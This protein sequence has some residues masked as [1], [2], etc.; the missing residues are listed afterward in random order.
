[1]DITAWIVLKALLARSTHRDKGSIS[2]FLSQEDQKYLENIPEPEKDPLQAQLDFSELLDKIHPSWIIAQLRSLPESEISLY[3]AS[4]PDH[5]AALAK[6]AFHSSRPCPELTDSAKDFVRSNMLS[7]FMD[8]VPD[9]IPISLLPHSPL[10]TLLNLPASSIQ[11]IIEYLGLHDLA[12]ELKIIIDTN[13]LK[14]IFLAL[15]PEK[16]S[17]LESLKQNKEPVVFKHMQL[18]KWA[19]EPSTLL[20]VVHHRGLNRLAKAIYSECDSFKWYLS[21]ML[22]CQESAL[23]HGLCKPL[24][25]PKAIQMLIHQILSLLPL[26]QNPL[27]PIKS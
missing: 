11:K 12:V 6:K 16:K 23:L 7:I 8:S 21:H 19:G 22:S 2:R 1:M 27:P 3:L 15:S 4:L 14:K 5:Q 26:V 9:L 20:Q 25:H 24:H 10:N 18:S 13:Q 17:Y